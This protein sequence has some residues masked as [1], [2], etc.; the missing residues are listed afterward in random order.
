MNLKFELV[1]AAAGSDLA[2]GMLISKSVLD[3]MPETVG[4]WSGFCE[5]GIHFAGNCY[6]RIGQWLV[7]RE[8]KKQ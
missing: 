6:D 3:R 2:P 1:G 7:W 5:K 4:P 8:A